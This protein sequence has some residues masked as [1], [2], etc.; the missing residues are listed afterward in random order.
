MGGLARCGRTR[1]HD[2]RTRPGGHDR[3][4]R[5]RRLRRDSGTGLYTCRTPILLREK[6]R[7]TFG[8][9]LRVDRVVAGGAKGTVATRND[10]PDLRI[11]AFDPRPA[12]NTAEFTVSGS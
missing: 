12:N 8:F 7:S 10:D 4:R 6:A 5:A 11:S 9:E 1:R 3:H 2:R